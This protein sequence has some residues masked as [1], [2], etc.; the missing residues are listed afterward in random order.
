MISY[1]F[2]PHFLLRVL[3]LEVVGLVVFGGVLL[4]ARSISLQANAPKK[5]AEP[6]TPQQDSDPLKRPRTQKQEQAAKRER[7]S[8]LDR[9]LLDVVAPIISDEE[10]RAFKKLGTNAERTQFMEDF[11]DPRNAHPES[12]GNEFKEEYFRRLV[13]A[14]ERFSAGMPGSRTDR[15]RI[16][17]IHGKPDSIE[18]YPAGGPYQRTAQEGGGRTQVFPFEIW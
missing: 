5:S 9:D 16:Y 1:K 15:G 13:Y 8:K 6:A 2:C 14:N 3:V 4:Q 11:W 12:E 10:L 18:S 7:L 17:I